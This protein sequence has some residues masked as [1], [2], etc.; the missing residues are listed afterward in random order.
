MTNDDDA[1]RIAQYFLLLADAFIQDGIQPNIIP[2]LFYK[3][4]MK[5][6][7]IL[8]GLPKSVQS[9]VQ[10][11]PVSVLNFNSKSEQSN[12]CTEHVELIEVSNFDINGRKR[13]LLD[14]EDIHIVHKHLKER[15]HQSKRKRPVNHPYHSKNGSIKI[16]DFMLNILNDKRFK[17]LAE[18]IDNEGAFKIVDPDKLSYFWGE[19]KR[20]KRQNTM[21]YEKFSRAL[22]YQYENG[23]MEKVKKKEYVFKFIKHRASS[24]YSF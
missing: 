9:N 7:E 13:G 22:R 23:E 4:G 17:H 24:S 11:V 21:N 19:T 20:S 15:P 8:S 6:V 12:N 5:A 2:D 14:C 18:W 1:V 10:S 3:N 16:I